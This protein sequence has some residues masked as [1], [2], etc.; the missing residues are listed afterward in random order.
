MKTQPFQCG[1]S[2]LPQNNR[3]C[4]SSYRDHYLIAVILSDLH[5]KS[6]FKDAFDYEMTLDT[7]Q[8]AKA[9]ETVKIPIYDA[10]NATR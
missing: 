3:K 6:F 5:V 4:Y 9:G 10:V 1:E 8:K 7:L 2:I